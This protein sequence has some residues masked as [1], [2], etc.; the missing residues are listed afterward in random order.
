MA[1][2]EPAAEID[3]DPFEDEDFETERSGFDLRDRA[4]LIPAALTGALL[5]LVGTCS[6]VVSIA[7]DPPPEPES[8]S[9]AVGEKSPEETP[10]AESPPAEPSENN[11]S[12]NE[13]FDD[14]GNQQTEDQEGLFDDEPVATPKPEGESP[15]SVAEQPAAETVDT[16]PAM[17]A[18]P[19]KTDEHGNAKPQADASGEI[20][21][22]LPKVE[23]RTPL[24]PVPDEALIEPTPAGPLPKVA[25]DGRSVWQTYNKPFR[26]TT[27]RPR[28]SIVLVELGLNQKNSVSAVKDTPGAVSLAFHPYVRNLDYWVQESRKAGHEV[29][30]MTPMEPF[31]YPNNDP[32]PHGLLTALGNSENQ[33][34]LDYVMSRMTGYVGLINFMG[35]RFTTSEPHVKLVTKTVKKRGLM[36]IENKTTEHSVLA[37]VAKSENVPFVQA[38]LM[39][40]SEPSRVAIR[41]KFEKLEEIA[42]NRGFASAIGQP[43]PV[44]INELRKWAEQLANKDLVLAPISALVPAPVK[45]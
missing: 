21:K 15:P 11:E 12:E 20:A 3:H 1:R 5:F 42:K 35:A 26:D 36:L 25:A 34:R 30:L 37:R 39:L 33:N 8:V 13:V 18:S 14:E 38:D 27:T 41:A 9:I 40:D 45:N 31:D 22:D 4:L 44:T 29:V 24:S 7:V 23:S 10:P 16:A 28:I 32:G 6:T 17:E 2:K 19:P 43:L